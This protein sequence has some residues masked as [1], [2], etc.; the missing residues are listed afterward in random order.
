MIQKLVHLDDAHVRARV[1]HTS[2]PRCSEEEAALL[3]GRQLSEPPLPRRER[4][5]VEGESS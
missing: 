2:N 1:V 5:P 4:R 3:Q